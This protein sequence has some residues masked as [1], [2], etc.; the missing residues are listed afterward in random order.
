MTDAGWL[1]KNRQI[2]LTG[3]DRAR[4][5]I[6]V[7]VRGA[8]EHMM[9]SVRAGVIV[10]LNAN[11]RAPIF[12]H[13]DVGVVGDWRETPPAGGR[14]RGKAALILNAHEWGSPNAPPLVCLHGVCGHGRRFRRLVEDHPRTAST[15]ALD[16]RGHGAPAGRSRT[17]A[18]HVEDVLETVTEP[19]TW[20]G[21]SF[22]GR[23][24]VEVTARR[25]DLVERAVLLD[26]ALWVPPAEAESAARYELSRGPWASVEEALAARAAT[27]EHTPR[28]LLEEEM[29]EHLVEQ[30]DGSWFTATP[31]RGRRCLPRDGQVPAALGDAAGADLLVVADHAKLV[32]RRVEHYR[33]ALGDLLEVAV[34]P[35]GHIVLWDAYEETSAA[36]TAF[37][38]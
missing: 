31:G 23:L 30:P 38:P 7:G 9:G 22:G 5:M 36:I 8:F 15:S 17:I 3:R 21:H 16:L 4:L 25:P 19:A 13:A 18:Q 14:A 2:G 35:G 29:R 32:S 33:A 34:V 20:I 6:E 37:L 11:E 1:P 27:V 28:E 12:E 26:P 10:G 24:T